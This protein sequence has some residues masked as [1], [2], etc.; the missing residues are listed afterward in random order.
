[1]SELTRRTRIGVQRVSREVRKN[2]P[3]SLPNIGVLRSRG[4]FLKRSFR[5]VAD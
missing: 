5:R 2:M 3:G 4:G 1:M